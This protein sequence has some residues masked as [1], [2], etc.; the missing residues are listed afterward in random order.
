MTY[1]RLKTSEP[2]GSAVAPNLAATGQVLTSKTSNAKP[3]RAT[4]CKA[5]V[6]SSSRDR[7]VTTGSPP[8]AWEAEEAHRPTSRLSSCLTANQPPT[9]TWKATTLTAS[10]REA[11]PFSHPW[12]PRAVIILSQRSHRR[13][14]SCS[15]TFWTPPRAWLIH[16]A[17]TAMRVSWIWV[18]RER[19]WSRGWRSVAELLRMAT[20]KARYPSS[21]PKAAPWCRMIHRTTRTMAHQATIPAK[22]LLVL[23][24][25]E[26]RTIGKDEIIFVDLRAKCW[27]IR[28]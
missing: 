7:A 27:W 13:R 6:S 12:L 2:E 1:S 8:T 17:V 5:T 15:I 11:A 21:G 23:D 25:D 4:S 24:L 10:D 3:L 9:S 22:I 19:R 20:S 14:R 16:V 28:W 26:I 18:R